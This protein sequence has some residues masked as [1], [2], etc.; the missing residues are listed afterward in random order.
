MAEQ[1]DA[2]RCSLPSPVQGDICGEN[3]GERTEQY[4]PFF[5]MCP[6]LR[7]LS[8]SN[9][10]DG[11]CAPVTTKPCQTSGSDLMDDDF[12]PSAPCFPESKEPQAES[13]S[14]ILDELN[15]S[16]SLPS[17]HKEHE[18]AQHPQE[19]EQLMDDSGGL[20]GETKQQPEPLGTEKPSSIDVIEKLGEETTQQSLSFPKSMQWSSCSGIEPCD[21]ES[22]QLSLSFSRLRRPQS[23]GAG[24]RNMG[25]TCFLNATLQCITHTV[26][27]FKKLRSTD[28][29]TPCSYD[30]DGFCSFCA[31]KEH[32]EESIRRS[33]SVLMPA[34]FKD[35]LRKLSSDFRPGQQEDAHE[36][37][38]CLLD[39]LHKC[40]LD[41]KSKGKPSS[42]DEESIV[43]RVFGGQLKS[44]L[45]CRECGHCSETSEPFLDLS[46]EIDQV[47]DLV[48]A[49]ESFTKVEE[50]GDAENK[51][52][53]ESCNVQVCKGKRLLL[54]KT[55]D[56]IAFQLKRFTTLDHSIEKIDKHV[57]YPSELD[58][59]PFH[60]NPVS[61]E[62]L[63]YDLYGVVEHSGLPNYG[64]YVCA[65]RSSPS[66]WH[67]MN[68]S[69]VDSITE[70][71]ALHQEAY[72]LFYVRQGI[73]PWFSSLLEEALHTE[74]TSGA[75][76]VSVLEDIDA[77]CSTSSNISSGDK[78]EKDENSP[79]KASFLPEEPTKRCAV[80]ASNSMSKQE[81]SPC[82]ASLQS[83]VVMRYSSN[84][85]EVTNPERPS[86]PPP[87]P[88]RLSSE[89]VLG[90]FDFEDLE[91]EDDQLMP[92]VKNQK[93]VK[94][95]KAASASKVVKGSCLDKNAS[96]LI[97]RM[98][99]AR[100][101]GL[102]ACMPPQHSVAQAPRSD[103]LDKKKRKINVS[104]PVLQY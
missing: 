43:K 91:D 27:L 15:K 94:K 25:N 86:T 19:I 56:V 75:S 99:S 5:S 30:E 46:L 42:F 39:N 17:M 67:L 103:P 82:R 95:P 80:D 10:W 97:N 44:Q 22:N 77:D 18:V 50:I 98:P 40:T 48:A 78:F 55:P 71:S 51:L 26:P 16:P 81:I 47:D 3:G 63:K 38:R 68:D 33:G 34:R 2:V 4:Q 61:E 83:D 76:P 45:T 88:K 74:T 79:C 87:R 24:L 1:D 54:D 35:N 20:D 29:P 21:K 72:I 41:P 73:F 58:L 57:A 59:K 7:T 89:G 66:T 62:E 64:H 65:I 85:T 104:V 6:P 90:V 36:F 92:I 23:V 32:I 11:V 52:T 8:Y 101:K 69:Q 93:K 100:R 49:L 84:G 60:S 14:D 96:H 53:C 37:L 9:S 12:M 70:T 102:L 31:L 13:I 28:H